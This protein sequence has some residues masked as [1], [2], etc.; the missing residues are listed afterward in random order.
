MQTKQNDMRTAVFVGSFNPFTIG[1]ASIVERGLEIFDHIVIGVG[2]NS[3]KVSGNEAD[4]DGRVNTIA[5]LYADDKRVEVKRY[6]GLTVD[7][8]RQEGARHV[9]KGVRSVRDF[10]YEREQ[11]DVNR[12]ISGIETVVLFALPSLTSVSSTIVRELKKYG[13]PTEQFIPHI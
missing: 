13:Y 10:E 9:L 8:A 11:A 4:A 5:R 1:H 7:F 12:A 2:I 6:E 3:D